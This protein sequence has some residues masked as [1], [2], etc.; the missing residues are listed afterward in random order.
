MVQGIAMR[1]RLDKGVCK[2][3]ITL[4]RETLRQINA[5]TISPKEGFFFVTLAP[6]GGQILTTVDLWPEQKSYF[7]YKFNDFFPFEDLAPPKKEK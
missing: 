3:W 5:K 2:K 7:Y 4:K 6:P 1:R